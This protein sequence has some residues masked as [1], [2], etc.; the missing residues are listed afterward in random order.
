MRQLTC[1]KFFFVRLANKIVDLDLTSSAKW[2]RTAGAEVR[3]TL[4]STT[5][6]FLVRM[7]K[8]GL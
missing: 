7:I 1:G 2:L 4:T 6:Y 8:P 3:K 5:S